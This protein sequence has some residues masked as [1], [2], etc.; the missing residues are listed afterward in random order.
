MKRQSFIKKIHSIISASKRDY[1]ISSSEPESSQ[2]VPSSIVI[3]DPELILNGTIDLL[4]D[5]T[6]TLGFEFDG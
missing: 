2:S 4:K 6:E 5:I 1:E 3:L